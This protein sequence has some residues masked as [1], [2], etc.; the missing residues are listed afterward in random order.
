MWSYRLCLAISGLDFSCDCFENRRLT[1]LGFT[2][3]I[4]ISFQFSLSSSTIFNLSGVC[5]HAGEHASVSVSVRTFFFLPNSQ[6]KVFIVCV[7][8]YGNFT[9]V[10]EIT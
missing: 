2:F 9:V 10:L 4:D 8:L 1:R 7:H 6:I 3:Y 5:F